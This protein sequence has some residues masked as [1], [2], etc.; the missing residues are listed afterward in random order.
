MG[1]LA[2][3]PGK[4]LLGW[5]IVEQHTHERGLMWYVLAVG[6][7]IA[8]L[9]YAIVARNFLFG[10]ILVM[11]GIIMATHSLRPAAQYRCSCSESGMMIGTRFYPWKDIEKFWLLVRPEVKTLYLEFGGLRP[12]LPVPLGEL[13][14]G[15]LH[16]I[17]VQYVEED[18]TNAEEPMSDWIVRVLKI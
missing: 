4:E 1:T 9:I 12:R 2:Q 18:T 15:Q 11:V 8:M 10:F 17:L 6:V 5:D 16:E 13:D 7:G 3:N 14:V